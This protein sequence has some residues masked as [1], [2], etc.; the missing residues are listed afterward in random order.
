MKKLY[1]TLLSIIFLLSASLS[2]GQLTVTF[3]SDRVVFQRNNL[4]N[5]TVYIGGYFTDCMDQVEARFVPIKSN[6]DKPELGQP[7]PSDGG[8]VIIQNTATC[9]NFS[10]SMNVSGGWYRLEVRGIRAGKEP[11]VGLV[12]HVGVGEVFLVAGQS[13]ATGGDTN[14]TGPGAVEDAVSSVDFR[15]MNNDAYSNFQLPCPEYVH[16]DQYTKTAP[17]GNYAWCWGSFGDKLVEKLNVPVM[18]FNAGWSATGI[19]N[20]KQSIPVNGITTAWF[21]ADYPAGLPF[22][23]LRIALNNYIAQLGIRA[24]LWHQGETDNLV[25][26][27]EEK[28]KD[29]LRSII[30]ESRDLSGKPNLPWIVA[31]ASRYTYQASNET[32]PSSHTADQIIAGQNDVIGIGTHG[33]DPN[34]KLEKVFEGPETDSYWD[35]RYRSDQV[36]FVGDGLLFLAQL[37]VDRVTD[38]FRNN[39]EP[40]QAIAP[41][42][43]TASTANTS[44]A[45]A[46]ADGWNSYNWLSQNDCNQVI[47]NS[48][49]WTAGTGLYRL[50][51]IDSHNNVVLSPALYVSGKALPVTWK[52]FR[53][54]AGENADATL[55]WATTDE[56]NTSYFEIQRGKD[57]FLFIPI[58]KIAASGNSTVTQEYI[59]KDGELKPGTY[60]YRLKQVDTDGK[61]DYS[62]IVSVSI[63]NSE[64]IRLFPNPVADNLS[65]QS[66]SGI[67]SIEIFNASGIKITSSRQSSNLLQLDMTKYPVGIYTVKVNGKNFR[68]LRSF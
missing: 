28:Y 45:F 3:P 65:I 31:R 10:G 8:W 61:F 32:A 2:F 38:D 66:D 50:K 52:Y 7:V 19:E 57:P 15:N 64:L 21:G 49:Q 59:Y 6:P 58:Q 43:I 4:N 27:S 14:P 68:I 35:S 34:Y 62:R 56:T 63:Y 41:A 55:E 40:Y 9:A 5:A 37:W 23:H 54:K 1:F 42:K 24:V 48:Q 20:W 33:N 46:A 11:V 18:I 30:Q 39:S 60:Y 51:T 12:Q 47:S 25:G 22:G 29:D 44:L 13:N 36:H 16:L 67:Y 26:T 53:A 17:F